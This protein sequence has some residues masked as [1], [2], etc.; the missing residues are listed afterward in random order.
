[1]IIP[2]GA[3]TPDAISTS[4]IKMLLGP[5]IHSIFT[6]PKTFL[7]LSSS[8]NYD[9]AEVLLI[10]YSVWAIEIIDIIRKRETNWL[11]TKTCGMLGFV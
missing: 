7:F 5:T 1:M 4:R 11:L 9:C 3:F 8:L 2:S 10:V 6:N